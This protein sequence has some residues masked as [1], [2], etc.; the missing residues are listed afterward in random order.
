MVTAQD[1]TRS[2]AAVPSIRE[3]SGCLRA[4]SSALLV[5]SAEGS[6]SGTGHRELDPEREVVGDMPGEIEEG[7]RAL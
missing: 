4:C 5:S 7:A 2:D 1:A 3:L 6:P